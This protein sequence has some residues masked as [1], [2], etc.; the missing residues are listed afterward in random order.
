[1]QEVRRIRPFVRA[2]FLGWGEADN[3]GTPPLGAPG[4]TETCLIHLSC[5]VLASS[6]V[7]RGHESS[8]CSRSFIN[9]NFVPF[10]AE[11]R[12][13]VLSRTSKVSALWVLMSKLGQR[14]EHKPGNK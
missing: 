7:C 9:N 13:T 11:Q 3:K 10:C 2:E 1:M 4:G 5:P 12:D 6:V 14:H 8:R